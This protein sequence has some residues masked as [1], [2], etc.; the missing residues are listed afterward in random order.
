MVLHAELLV[1]VGHNV[2]ISNQIF[3][4]EN[5]CFDSN[6]TSKFKIK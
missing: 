3:P 2:S 6:D 1:K 5:A 4:E